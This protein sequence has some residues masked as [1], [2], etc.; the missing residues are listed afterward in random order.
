MIKT[1]LYFLTGLLFTAALTSHA[2]SNL[3]QV[4]KDL[5]SPEAS[6]RENANSRIVEVFES[7]LPTIATETTTICTA[8]S[9]N[10]WYIR[11]QASGLLS[12][13]TLLYP[14]DLA[15]VDACTPQL[16]VT[17]TD[18]TNQVKLNSLNA[19]ANKTDG[20]PSAAASAFEAALSD[21]D[22]SVK[23]LGSTGIMKLPSD[24]GVQSRKVLA[25]RI[26][27]EKAADA[28]S[29]LL[30]GAMQSMKQ[31]ADVAQ[32]ASRLLD[33][34][35]SDVRG[36]AIMAVETLNSDKA[37]ALRVLEN[38]QGAAKLTPETKQRLQ[39]SIRRLQQ[40]SPVAR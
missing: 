29:A 4:F 24:V 35:S 8:L 40:Q 33:D 31:D 28:R 11:Q 37:A 15:V 26:G 16:L 14:Q 5:H 17:A 38:Q 36:S 32:A 2:Q 13:L 20:P 25:A 22:S 3:N 34:P 9:D 10:D 7:E 27:S 12:V 21:P 18:T 6:V 1:R 19:L 30:L 39:E 23:Q